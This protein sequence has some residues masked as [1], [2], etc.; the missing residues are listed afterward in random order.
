MNNETILLLEKYFDVAFAAPD[1]VK[2][3]RELIL[4]LAM[5]GKLVPQD[6]SD[7]PARELLK[8]IE[9]EKSR[10]VKDGK[11]KASKPLPEIKPDEVPYDLPKSW[12]WVRL[13]NCLLK[14]TDGTHHSPINTESGD[15]LYI[16]AKN[17]KDD[18][19]LLNNATYV[20]KEIHKEIFSR[21]DPE[22]GNILYIK[23]GA[24]TG[25]VT[26]NNLQ[27]PFSMLSSVALLKQPKQVDNYY[28]LFTLRSPFFYNEI[29]SGM[30]GVAITRVTLTKLNDS[31]IPLPPI[32]EQRR[33]VAKI[34]E[35][36]ARCDELEKLRQVYAQKQITV[37]NAAL[38][39]LLTAKDHNDFKTSWHFITQHFGELY[40]VNANVA[41]LRKAIL[42]LAVMGKLVPQDPNDQPASELLKEIEKEKQKLIKEGK[43]KASKPLP[44]I[45]HDEIPYDLPKG[46]EWVR[47]EQL[48]QVITKGSSPNWQ[49][50]QYVN[51]GE[52]ILFITSENVGNYE[53]LLNKKKFVE[54][55]FNEIE[56]RS[57]LQ[58]L[59]IL[60]N[61]VGASIGRTAIFD[62]DELANINQA[63]TIIRLI[64]LV[65]HI[66]FLHFFNSPVCIYYM[67]DKQ[68]E[69][70]RPNLSMG[71]IALFNIPLPP[72][73]EQHRIVAKIDQLMT[74]CDELEK[75]I[76]IA[77]SKKTNLLNSVMTKV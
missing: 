34:D 74:L 32:A 1:G 19:V 55:K 46:W 33:I 67:Y 28:L 13:G 66:Y 47:L 11:I 26:I 31:L 17:I 4:S 7:Q 29:R 63:V 20:T 6:P 57:I 71:S 27:K 54:Y 38:N 14:I 36:M 40:S 22:Y 2:K 58:R 72:L 68:V 76:D 56:P 52:G 41:E 61:I 59:D 37:H 16:S 49:G 73:A 30:T 18:G 70:A 51:E 65:D 9:A 43:I 60:M 53:L 39:Q 48:T 64:K 62:L 23:D 69:N 12:E 8:E 77:N 24:T 3:L 21:C 10:L 35:L 75:Q 42:Q 25:V 44:E 50:V 15:F 5:Q 45:K